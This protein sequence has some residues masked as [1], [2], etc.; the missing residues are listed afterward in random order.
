MAGR[1]ETLANIAVIL[2]CTIFG[3]HYGT[4]LYSRAHPAPPPSPYKAGDMIQDTPELGLR[5][6]G[7][8]MLL[9]TRSVCHFCSASMPFY[10]RMI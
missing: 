7:M 4:D 10:R 1:L 5:K 2:A 3:V 6:A 8:T 9:V